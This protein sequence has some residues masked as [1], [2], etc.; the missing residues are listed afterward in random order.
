MKQQINSDIKK[1]YFSAL[2]C[3]IM[4][5]HELQLLHGELVFQLYTDRIPEF[6]VNILRLSRMH[7]VEPN[8]LLHPEAIEEL[9][10]FHHSDDLTTS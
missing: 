9:Y 4:A 2:G 1:L 7:D 10:D 8:D 6:Y 3:L 5:L